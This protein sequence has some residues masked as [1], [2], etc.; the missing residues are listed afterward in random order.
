MLP[1]DHLSNQMVRDLAWIFSSHPL[2]N[3]NQLYFE[4]LALDLNWL[5]ALDQSAETIDHFM[6][7]KNL[8]MLGTYFEA[9]WDFFFRHYPGYKLIAKNLQVFDSDKT[10]GEFDFIYFNQ[11]T[12]EHCHLEVAIKYYLGLNTH[13]QEGKVL[14]NQSGMKRWVGPN[15]NDRLDKKYFKMVEHQSKLSQTNA[16][17]KALEKLGINN[18]KSEVCLLGYL[19]YPAC[20]TIQPPENS[21]AKHN[22]GC[23]LKYSQAA[24]VLQSDDLWLLINKPHW[25]APMIKSAGQLDT[26]DEILYKLNKHFLESSQPILISNFRLEDK[27]LN[28][29]YY[30]A[31]KY[32]IV[33]ENWPLKPGL[34]V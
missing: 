17:R 33:P 11:V 7:N 1:P 23:W 21:H 25:M 18:I 30:S 12:N 27:S 2:I 10:I 31:N 14:N 24:E 22:R 34:E 28:N 8:R 3:S 16:G 13:Q 26:H 5:Q 6:A 29:A 4:Q 20:E 9:L 19:F 32:F 15:V